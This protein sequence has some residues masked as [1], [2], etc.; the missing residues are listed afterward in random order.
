MK[1]LIC[2]IKG[3][4]FSTSKKVNNLIKEFECKN[5]KQ[6]FTTD[7]YGNIIKL[8]TYWKD[9]NAFFEKYFL[10]KSL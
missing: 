4:H 9:N 5:C 7:G 8:T 1:S 3:H 2:K 6:K 10:K